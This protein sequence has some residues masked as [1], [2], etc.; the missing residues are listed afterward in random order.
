MK[1]FGNK[2]LFT[3]PTEAMITWASLAREK[4]GNQFCRYYAKPKV[5]YSYVTLTTTTYED[6]HNLH[7]SIRN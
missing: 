2:L 1:P 7:A 4:I 3:S 5:K 6:V